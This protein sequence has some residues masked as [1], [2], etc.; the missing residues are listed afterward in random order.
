[1][2]ASYLR[3]WYSMYIVIYNKFTIIYYLYVLE[4]NYLC[5]VDFRF[6]NLWWKFISLSF[7]ARFLCGGKYLC[8]HSLLGEWLYW[9]MTAWTAGVIWIIPFCF[10][11]FNFPTSPKGQM[12]AWMHKQEDAICNM[13]TIARQLSSSEP[14]PSIAKYP[15]ITTGVYHGCHFFLHFH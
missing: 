14:S 13:S 1:M 7:P 3:W 4:A 8:E 2:R 10:C 15:K 6:S 9:Y 11:H 12:K 5:L